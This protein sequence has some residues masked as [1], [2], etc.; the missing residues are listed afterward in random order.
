[1][2]LEYNELF[3]FISLLE[4]IKHKNTRRLTPFIP[5][6]WNYRSR[7]KKTFMSTILN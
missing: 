2:E 6:I 5:N 1:M 7:E 4:N 3:V